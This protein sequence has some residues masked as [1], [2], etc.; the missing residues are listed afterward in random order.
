ML[1]N[2][3]ILIV[4]DDNAI[5]DLFYE[6]FS[7]MGFDASVA[8]NGKSA[9]EFLEKACF[10]I[11]VTDYQMPGING[12]ELTKI[13]RSR[14]VCSLIIGMSGNCDDMDFLNAG[15]NF[16][17]RKPFPLKKLLSIIQR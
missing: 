6:F 5:R 16:F 7:Q 15:A 1:R 9:V 4:D 13:L 3:K 14:N 10:D 12:I 8:C 17:L 11:I 2:K